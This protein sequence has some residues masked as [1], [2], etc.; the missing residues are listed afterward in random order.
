M[1]KNKW[2]NCWKI[3]CLPPVEVYEDL[4]RVFETNC[5]P[6]DMPKLIK[7]KDRQTEFYR[8]AYNIWKE[9]FNK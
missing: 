6:E 4:I 7:E 1:K 8:E 2:K 5:I 9:K 3:D